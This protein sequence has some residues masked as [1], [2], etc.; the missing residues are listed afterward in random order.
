MRNALEAIQSG[1]VDLAS[2]AVHK[3]IRELDKSATRGVLHHNNAARRKSRLM[4]KLNA[5]KEDSTASD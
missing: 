2:E 4:K 5:L 1:D 3:A